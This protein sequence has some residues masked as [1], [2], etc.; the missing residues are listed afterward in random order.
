MHGGKD[1]HNATYRGV[2][3][4]PFIESDGFAPWYD[5]QNLQFWWFESQWVNENPQAF[6]YRVITYPDG[7]YEHHLDSVEVSSMIGVSVCLR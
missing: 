2:D 3:L 4:A 1:G 5:D 7:S 6:C